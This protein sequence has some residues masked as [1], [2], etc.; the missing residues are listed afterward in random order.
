M[1][2]LAIDPGYERLGIAVLEKFSGNKNKEYV[3]FSECFRTSQKSSFEERLLAVGLEVEK[4]IEEYK[5]TA[6]VI[7]NLFLINN[8]KTAMRVSEV[9]GAILYVC[10]KNKLEIKELTPLQI[11]MAVTGNGKSAKDQVIK[12]VKLL[13]SNPKAN[14]LDDEY[15]AIAA[16]LAFFALNKNPLK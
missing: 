8:Q 16:G 3:V 10:K 7:E 5:P 13:V 1:R 11:K 6:L 4:M 15:D 14:V 2:V 9:R 12:M